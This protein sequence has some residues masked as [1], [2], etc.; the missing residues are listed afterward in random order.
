MSNCTHK[1]TRIRKDRDK[2]IVV[3]LADGSVVVVVVSGGERGH[4]LLTVSAPVG[5][6][7]RIDGAVESP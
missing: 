6:D 1:S 5:S 2:R 4:R 7:V 3:R